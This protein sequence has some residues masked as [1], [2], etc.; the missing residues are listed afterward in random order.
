[1]NGSQGPFPPTIYYAIAIVIANVIA[2]L[3]YGLNRNRN[4]KHG[5]TTHSSTLELVHTMRSY[6]NATVIF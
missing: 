6:V 3:F 1:M 5:C 2:I 4:R